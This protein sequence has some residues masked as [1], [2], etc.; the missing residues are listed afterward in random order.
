MTTPEDLVPPRLGPDADAVALDL[1]LEPRL[2]GREPEEEV[3]LLG[4]LAGQLVVG[5]DVPRLAQL[6]LVLEALAARAVPPGVAAPVD[7]VAAVGRLR[8]AQHLPQLQDA[9]AVN[10]LG[11][12]DE[13]VEA[14]VVPPPQRAELGR[15]AVA[16]LLLGDPLLARDPLDVLPVLVGPRQEEH[17]A[18]GEALGPRE[19]VGGD[20]RVR[21]ADVRNVVDVVDRGRDE[22]RALRGGHLLFVSAARQAAR[23]AASTS[24]TAAPW[25]AAARSQ[26]PNSGHAL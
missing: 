6:L 15:D 1:V 4:P 14:D 3:L 2:V 19:R 10:V 25:A 26:S 13:A 22:E 11:R 23:A 7:R 5:A 21:V 9:A 12:A 17:V 20:R 16:V 18:A 24:F 8:D